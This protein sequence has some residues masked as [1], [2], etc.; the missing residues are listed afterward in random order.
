LTVRFNMPRVSAFDLNGD[1]RSGA[2]LYFYEPSTTTEKAVYS[3]SGL[4]TV[5]SQP[6]TA[7]SSGLWATIFMQASTYRVILKDSAG[8]TIWDEDNYDPGLGAG[9]GV[10]STV[11]VAQG[12][13]GATTAAAARTNLGAASS[14]TLTS[15]QDTVTE[16]ETFIDSARNVSVTT[17]AGL[18]AKEDTVSTSLLATS[19][20]VITKQRLKDT[21]AAASTTTTT[22]PAY[23]TSTPQIGEGTEIFSQAITPTSSSSV[24]KIRAFLDMETSAASGQATAAIFKNSDAD[25]L[26]AASSQAFGAGAN[27]FQLYLEYEESAASTAARTYSLRVGTN[28][29]TLRIN[30]S[31]G[32]GTLNSKRVSFLE[33]TEELTV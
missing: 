14:A 18:L 7:S 3:D 13:T 5:I 4:T 17:R 9:F 1:P 20:G 19:F 25:A 12:G 24:I 23:D 10:S 22:T 27:P 15:V 11:A 8:T 33:V 6:V 26:A 2:K 29:G 21:T 28:S 16:H 31:G 32:T 30:G